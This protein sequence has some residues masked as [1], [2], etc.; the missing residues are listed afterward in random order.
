MSKNYNLFISHSWTYNLDACKKKIKFFERANLKHT[1]L[2]VHSNSPEK[3]ELSEKEYIQHI[4]RAIKKSDCLLILAG[5]LEE[6]N[7]WTRKEVELA[8]SNKK[9]IIVIEPWLSSRTM[10]LLNKEADIIVKW[11]GKKISEAIRQFGNLN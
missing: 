7:Y 5:T 6:Q 8:K 2:E 4:D 10:P 11:N 9:P 3:G 1:F